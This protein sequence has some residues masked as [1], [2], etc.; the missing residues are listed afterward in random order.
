ML[1]NRRTQ[2]LSRFSQ[3]ISVTG[4]KT[5]FAKP[6]DF[7]KRQVD[8]WPKLGLWGFALVAVL[9]YPLGAFLTHSIDADTAYEMPPTDNQSVAL[10]TSAYLIKREINDKIWTP[11][12]PFFFPAYVLDNMPAFQ[13]GLVSSIADVVTAMSKRIPIKKDS[14][15]YKA[16][17]LLNYPPTIWMFSPQNKLLPAPS[18]NSQYRRARKFLLK[19]NDALARGETVFLKRP[20]DLAFILQKIR[21]GLQKSSDAL[22]NHIRENS[23]GLFDNKADDVFYFQQGKLYGDY[24]LLKALSADYKDIIVA[25][26]LYQT[27]TRLLKTLEDASHLSP[28]IV[29]NGELNSSVAPNHLAVMGYYANRAIINLQELVKNLEK[30]PQ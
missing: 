21:Y 9:Y 5:F 6:L 30:M 2:L 18:S 7:L 13:K 8:T 29:R 15:L 25:Q 24:L 4:I 27:W 14:Y 16:A 3:K 10:G 19:Y 23:G 17:E 28:L 20:Q 12:L 22:E 1:K 26:N 11:N